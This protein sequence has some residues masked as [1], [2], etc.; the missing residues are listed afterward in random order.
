MADE[1]RTPSGLVELFESLRRSPYQHEF[2]SVLRQLDCLAADSPRSG[3]A[4]R[5]SDEPVRFGQQPSLE[6]AQST[7]AGVDDSAAGLPPRVLI[8]F[9]GLLGPNGPLPLHLTEYAL[10]RIRHHRDRT[11][12]QFLDIFHHR[13]LMLFYRAWAEGQPVVN[14]DRADDDRFGRYIGSM[15][16]IGAASLENRDAM[17]DNLMRFFAGR[18]ASEA[19]NPSGLEAV[20]SDFFRLP[21]RIQEFVGQWIEM[22]ADCRCCLGANRATS[23]LGKNMMIGSEYWDRQQKFRIAFGPMGYQDYRRMLPG[24]DSLERLIAIVRN[25]LG[26][27]L[28]W[29]VQLILTKDE[30]PPISLGQTGELGWSDW[31]YSG[32]A[33]RDADD[34]ALL[35]CEA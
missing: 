34:L 9:F 6:Y 2:Y 24:G 11:F 27:E 20:L 18:F 25:Y 33:V 10:D 19:K 3:H 21:V 22:P 7:I 29:D 1:N 23:T 32:D 14:F 8:R 26:D 28:Q 12:P 4:S 13:L 15:V 5:P 16:G 17:P 30:V 31:L 35:G